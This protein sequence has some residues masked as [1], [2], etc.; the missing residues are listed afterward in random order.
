MRRSSSEEFELRTDTWPEMIEQLK[1]KGYEVDSAY[2]RTPEKFVPTYKDGHTWLLE[3]TQYFRGDFEV[4]SDNITL[5][6]ADDVNSCDTIEASDDWEPEDYEGGYTE[7]EE[8]AS[9]QVKDSDGF[10]TD[11]TMWYNEFEDRY[12]FTFGDKDI[13]YPENAPLDWE[14]E[15]YEEAKE[16]FDDYKGFDDD[17][18]WLEDDAVE[19]SQVIEASESNEYP[20]KLPW[21]VLDVKEVEEDS[22]DPTVYILWHNREDGRYACT[23][24]DPEVTDPEYDADYE[25][26]TESD[27]RAWFSGYDSE[28]LPGL[29]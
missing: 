23:Y 20:D 5:D 2:R 3:V 15:T 21:E 18:D 14:C 27:A 8:V 1:E 4:R 24:G 19:E 16:W 26:M 9:K 25:T 7:W 13:Y 17:D 6:D 22:E 11:Y 12:A 28:P 29:R 10:W